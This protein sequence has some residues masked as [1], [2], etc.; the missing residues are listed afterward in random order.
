MA[1]VWAGT[2]RFIIDHTEVSD[3]LRGRGIGKQLV[4]AAVHF[5]RE[6][7]VTILPLCPFAK[8]VFGRVPEFRDV[9]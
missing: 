9:L 6:R 2:Q 1:Y 8:G 7:S 3:D 5:A 4:A